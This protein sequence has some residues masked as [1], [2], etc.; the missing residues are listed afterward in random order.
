MTKFVQKNF[1]FL[2]IIKLT[3]HRVHRYNGGIFDAN[4]TF[5]GLSLKS[6][7]CDGKIPNHIQFTASHNFF[8]KKFSFTKIEMNANFIK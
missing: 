8:K 5:C 1:G 4:Y 7:M 2:L 6:K 3:V